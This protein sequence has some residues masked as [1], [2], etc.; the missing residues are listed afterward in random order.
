MF[1]LELLLLSE[2]KLRIDLL[3][4]IK[5]TMDLTYSVY[6][7]HSWIGPHFIDTAFSYSQSQYIAYNIYTF[8]IV[9]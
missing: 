6:Q 8:C 9:L 3:V 4:C 5:E 1:W 2:A 7:L